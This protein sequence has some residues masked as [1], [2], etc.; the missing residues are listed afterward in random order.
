MVN[1]RSSLPQIVGD[2][3]H[4]WVVYGGLY[5]FIHVDPG[6]ANVRSPYQLIYQWLMVVI[7]F[8]SNKS[9]QTRSGGPRICTSKRLLLENA[10]KQLIRTHPLAKAPAKCRKLW[11]SSSRQQLFPLVPEGRAM[12]Q[13]PDGR[14]TRTQ[15]DRSRRQLVV[16]KMLWEM[17][18]SKLLQY[19]YSSSSLRAWFDNEAKRPMYTVYV[20][21]CVCVEVRACACMCAH[22]RVGVCVC[23]RACARGVCVCVCVCG[24]GG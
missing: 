6:F 19:V 2:F 24:C 13:G 15:H 11:L 4:I 12:K 16:K 23:A 21:L 7:P 10:A 18:T 22:A 3:S 1:G 8:T 5:C 17:E 20:S 9:V 14:P